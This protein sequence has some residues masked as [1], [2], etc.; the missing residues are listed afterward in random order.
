MS[1]ASVTPC[2]HGKAGCHTLDFVAPGLFSRPAFRLRGGVHPNKPEPVIVVAGRAYDLLADEI[3]PRVLAEF[4]RKADRFTL[5]RYLRWNDPNGCYS[6][7]DS[8]AEFGRVSR[9]SDLRA[10]ARDMLLGEIGS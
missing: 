2:P 7:S 9:T 8:R 3:C 1:A 10:I 6:D 5:I 4:A